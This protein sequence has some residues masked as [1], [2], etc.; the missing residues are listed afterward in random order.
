MG[1]IEQPEWIAGYCIKKETLSDCVERWEYR[2][3]KEYGHIYICRPW[4]GVHLWM[5][6]VYMHSIPTECLEEYHFIKLN[7]CAEGRSEVLLEDERYV[8]LEK[9]ILSVDSNTPKKNFLFPGGRYAG[10]ELI[11]DMK[12]LEKQPVQAFLDCGIDPKKMR[13]KLEDMQGSYL[14]CVSGEWKKLAECVMERLKRADA[15][16]EEYRFFTLQ[17]LYSLKRADLVLVEQKFYLTKGQRR[18]VASVEEKISGDLKCRY[19]V[20]SLAKEQ[21]IS[22]SSL[23]KYFE[24]VYGT[25]IS[26]YI[27]RKRMEHACRLLAQT[28]MSV[29]DI[30]A[31]TGYGNQGKFAGVFKKYTQKTPLEY[32]R[33]HSAD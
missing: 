28:R 10:L 13:E 23:K 14:A 16:A 25:S 20:E 8:Y 33:L 15:G 9:G 31:E 2:F 18:I 1:S 24:K 6:D 3:Q 29:A 19:T 32:R 7:Y 22:P 12:V 30:A 17:L 4:P 26:D 5:N 21:G 27:R 11:L